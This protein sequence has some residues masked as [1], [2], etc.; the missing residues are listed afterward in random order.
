MSR[1][2][3]FAENS[4]S[5]LWNCLSSDGVWKRSPELMPYLA[6]L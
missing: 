3:S 4:S 6:L 1:T 5:L 2:G